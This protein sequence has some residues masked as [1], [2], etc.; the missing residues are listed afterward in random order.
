MQNHE[1]TKTSKSTFDKEEINKD[2]TKP[3]NKQNVKEIK[4]EAQPVI[5]DTC[6][7]QMSHNDSTEPLPSNIKFGG[8]K[9]VSEND[10]FANNKLGKYSIIQTS[11]ADDH[12]IVK[13][14]SDNSTKISYGKSPEGIKEISKVGQEKPSKIEDK[15]VETNK[16][17][18]PE[19]EACTV[20]KLSKIIDEQNKLCS[21]RMKNEINTGLTRK[22]YIPIASINTQEEEDEKI[23]AKEVISRRSRIIIS[24]R[25]SFTKLVSQIFNELTSFNKKHTDTN[26]KDLKPFEYKFKS[27]QKN[28]LKDIQS[29]LRNKVPIEATIV[30]ESEY[31]CV[32]YGLTISKSKTTIRNSLSSSKCGG[33]TILSMF[34]LK[35]PELVG[36]E[37][38]NH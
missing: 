29:F 33:V 23:I 26:Q 19:K 36:I 13:K 7:T 10:A 11:T 34:V 35:C 21:L 38:S 28:D 30:C 25:Q 27:A 32:V 9:D 20:T 1:T 6:L 2:D 18:N 8:E 15:I 12:S 37:I 17:K 24:N 14:R 31:T 3:M 16:T 4:E 22:S 5:K